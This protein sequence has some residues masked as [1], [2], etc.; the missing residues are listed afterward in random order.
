[1]IGGI[2]FL[3]RI[4]KILFSYAVLFQVFQVILYQLMFHFG[5]HHSLD[6]SGF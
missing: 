1:M 2:N 4:P 3:L 6:L 5:I